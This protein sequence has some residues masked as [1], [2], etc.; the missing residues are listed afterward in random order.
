MARSRKKQKI[1][2]DT[3]GLKVIGAAFVIFLAVVLG[4]TYQSQSPAG[5]L[6]YTQQGEGSG[7]GGGSPV[8]ENFY[9]PRNY[10][11]Y[12]GQN[13]TVLVYAN[14]RQETLTYDVGM[15]FNSSYLQVVN[16]TIADTLG[17]GAVLWDR[18][19]DTT[20]AKVSVIKAISCPGIPP[21]TGPLMKV[22]FHI[23]ENAPLGETR[24]YIQELA[25]VPGTD[26]ALSNCTS[27]SRHPDLQWGRL[28]VIS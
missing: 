5:A 1:Q 13:V 11:G 15:R 8:N 16:V 17:Q 9:F 18:G 4:A 12:R 21:S 6:V 7:G 26:N 28:T 10:N 14:L 19:W 2:R 22:T 23:K 20:W 3:T 24:M 27:Q 25:E